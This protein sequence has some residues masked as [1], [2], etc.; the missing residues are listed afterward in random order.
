M[1]T[2]RRLRHL[3]L[4]GG[5]HAHA[6]LLAGLARRPFPGVRIT[7]VS[8]GPRAFYSG[9][10]PGLVAGQYGA[11]DVTID[12]PRLAARAGAGFVSAPAVRVAA[13][14]RTVETADGGL[15]RYDFAC[16]DVGSTVSGLE[17]PGVRRVALPTR[18]VAALVAAVPPLLERARASTEGFRVIV[19]GGGAGGVELA[20][21]LQARLE[22]EGIRHPS[23][24]LLEASPRLLPGRTRAVATAVE[25]RCVARG[26]AVETGVRVVRVED[27]RLYLEDGS[28]RVFEALLWC[29]GAAAL[30]FV[31]ASQLPV[32]ER[33]FLR[34]RPTLQSV[35]HDDL[36]AVGDVASL[37]PWPDMPKAGVY[38][39]RAAPV[40][41][42]NL[43]AWLTGAPLATFRPQRDFLTLLNL[44]DGRALGF[45]WGRVLEGRL[46]FRLKDWI[47]RGFMA[48]FRADTR[49]PRVSPARP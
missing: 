33:G 15:L 12:L 4:V 44:G 48:R 22:R 26:I 38:A 30:P 25:R 29:T 49:D 34:V 36:F 18:P 3:V 6:L 24:S 1:R 9:M 23:V 5:G 37:E 19:V 7:L 17:I 31:R 27:G 40:L 8:D 47:D 21:A 11:D 43:R 39:V 16:L 20:C 45:K 41:E 46:V 32:D 14:A 42:R 28:P 10:V 13:S 35:D 2:S